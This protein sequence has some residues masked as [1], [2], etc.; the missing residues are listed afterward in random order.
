MQYADRM[1]FG[2]L[3]MRASSVASHWAEEERRIIEIERQRL[4]LE[5]TI[6][7]E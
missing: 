2:S 1:G 6:A 3:R 5:E 4:G 7:V